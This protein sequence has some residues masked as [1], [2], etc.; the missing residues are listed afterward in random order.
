M[1]VYMI[2]V[3]LAVK[4]GKNTLV[5]T[6]TYCEVDLGQDKPSRIV[7]VL[8][9]GESEAHFQ[10]KRGMLFDWLDKPGKDVFGK[11]DIDTGRRIIAI[12]DNHL[13]KGRYGSWR[14]GLSVKK[15]TEVYKLPPDDGDP[16][17][18]NPEGTDRGKNPVIINR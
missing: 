9:D 12:Q 15:G 16:H 14:Y 13:G 5:L 4:D 1:A 6:P 3:S 7:W 18:A 10:L 8:D 11:A 17:E 2:K